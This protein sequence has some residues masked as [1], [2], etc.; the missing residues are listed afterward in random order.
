MIPFPHDNLLHPESLS[1]A[2]GLGAYL[3][4]SAWLGWRMARAHRRAVERPFNRQQGPFFAPWRLA[5]K[6][7]L[8]TA[9][10][11]LLLLALLVPQGEPQKVE[12][13]QSGADVVLCVDVS[14]SMY[15]QDVHPDRLG[16]AKQAPGAFIDRLG[17]DRVG[18]VAFAG[19]AVLACP[20]TTDYETAHLFL[21][22]LDGDSVPEDG[23]GLGPALAACLDRFAFE[24]NRGRLIVL[25]TDGED[26]A[27][28][29]TDAE[30]RRCGE[31]STP[32]FALGMGTDRGGTVPG[33]RDAFGRVLAK[34]Y[35]GQPV[36]S[37]RD[38][39]TLERV[40][41]LSGGEYLSGDSAEAAGRAIERL[42][43]LKQGRAKAPD[44]WVRDPLYQQPLLWA[45]ILLL[46]EALIPLQG[47]GLRHALAMAGRGLAGL[48]GLIRRRRGWG[49]AGMLAL[50]LLAARA[51]AF[52]LD[53]GRSE[54]DQG[55]QAY[56]SSDF[57]AAASYYRDS[58][59][60]DASRE[61][62]QYNMGNAFYRQ[63]DYPSAA[64]AYEDALKLDP[65]DED[66]AHNL[67][68]AR[69]HMQDKDK[70]DDKKDDKDKKDKQGG[71]DKQ[72][73]KGGQGK[74]QQGKGGQGKD[75]DQQRSSQ[76][77]SK[78]NKDEVAAMMRMLKNDRQ[79]YDQ[80]FQPLKKKQ[81]PSQDPME[82]M[83][84]Q[85]TGMP[86]NPKPAQAGP[87]KKDW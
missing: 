71:K 58:L 87:E 84:E 44:R 51:R 57:K 11:A 24:P 41:Q 76:A 69:Q 56:R 73:G 47:G 39:S 52:S 14:R 7:L 77:K 28:E 83:F 82:Q 30:A 10:L 4:L 6:W 5:L 23:T 32:V 85:M 53:P 50:L 64:Q 16:L 31:A 36:V 79:R 62:A 17:G 3:L 72:D 60:Q 21:D 55:N 20:F 80:A 13:E 19:D 63:G 37:R 12:S 74:D 68:L 33:E 26:L 65:K 35:H 75:Q 48:A 49:K 8:L 43:Q 45:L 27:G 9:G 22:K 70:K 42:R 2:W 81:Q 18:I 38:P 34:V 66:A 61:Q 67:E 86:M 78:L 15:T 40:A 25:A 1:W 29:D 59:G 54:Y 46:A